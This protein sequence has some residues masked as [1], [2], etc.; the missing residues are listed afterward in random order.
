MTL[1]Y[2]MRGRVDT[3]SLIRRSEIVIFDDKISVVRARGL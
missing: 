3:R 2:I 1:R